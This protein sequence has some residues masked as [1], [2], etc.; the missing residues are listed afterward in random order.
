MPGSNNQQVDINTRVISVPSI[1]SHFTDEQ[2]NSEYHRKE[3]YEEAINKYGAIFKH[4]SFSDAKV[5]NLA[6]YCRKWIFRNYYDGVRSFNL[7]AIDLAMVGYQTD[8]ILVGDR[9]AVEYTTNPQ[10]PVPV[11]RRMTCLSAQYDLLNPQNTTFK[12]GIPDVSA[13]IKYRETISVNQR[14]TQKPTKPE[15]DGTQLR[16]DV[17]EI[18]V[19][20][21]LLPDDP[22]P[23]LS[24]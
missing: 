4:V 14:L 12:I 3:D 6:D 15:D 1:V 13:N 7:K 23:P 17:H 9:V 16:E 8:K 22:P 19:E 10:I 20:D 5:E 24:E 11:T 2:L 18:E 21:G